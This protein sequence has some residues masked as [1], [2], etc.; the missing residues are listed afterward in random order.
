MSNAATLPKPLHRKH[1]ARPW[2]E[3]AKRWESLLNALLCV[4]QKCN[5]LPTFA[6]LTKIWQMNEHVNT[7]DDYLTNGRLKSWRKSSTT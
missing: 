4:F 6:L 5:L 3:N 2:T 1:E 7:I